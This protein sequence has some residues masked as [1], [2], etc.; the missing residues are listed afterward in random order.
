M[1]K[2]VEDRIPTGKKGQAQ[3]HMTEVDFTTLSLL[4]SRQKGNFLK[5]YGLRE[6]LLCS[7]CELLL[8]RGEHYTRTAFY[9]SQPQKQHTRCPRLKLEYR[10]RGGRL[11]RQGYERRLVNYPLL[12]QFQIGV[13]WKA[14]V[15]AGKAFKDVT[16]PPAIQERM[17]QSLR[18]G[19]VDET[20]V[21]CHMLKL[22]GPLDQCLEIVTIEA[23]PEYALLVMG[24]YAWLYILK[25]DLQ[26]MVT[27]RRDGSLIVLVRDWDVFLTPSDLI[28]R[29]RPSG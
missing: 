18:T 15:A 22:L 16:C 27:F 6:E 28:A 20:L 14:S 3:P 29:M 25:D 17:R 19:V 24:G 5:D 4:Y 8:G 21:P 23:K 2:E 10:Q 12:R 1:L 7:D 11:V 9:G 26:E 13:F